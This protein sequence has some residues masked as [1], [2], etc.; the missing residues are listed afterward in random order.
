MSPHFSVYF[1]LGI[2]WIGVLPSA[3]A[4]T[5]A[6][7]QPLSLLAPSKPTT[8]FD[9]RTQVTQAISL[10][11]AINQ[12]LQRNPDLYAARL[13]SQMAEESLRIVQAKLLPTVN[14]LLNVNSA[15]TS[16]DQIGTDYTNSSLRWSSALPSMTLRSNWTLFSS[17]LVQSQLEAATAGL[18]VSTLE[19]ERQIQLLKID[20]TRAYIALQKAQSQLEI[21]KLTLA[22]SKETLQDTEKLAKARVQTQFEVLRA[23]VQVLKAQQGVLDARSLK[24]VAQRDLARYLNFA[25]PTELSARDGIAASTPWLFSLEET[26]FQ[27][28]NNRVEL[29]QAVSREQ[30]AL[31]Q[32][33]A[34]LAQLGPQVQ[35]I[36]SLGYDNTLQFGTSITNYAGDGIPSTLQLADRTLTTTVGFQVS[37]PLTDGGVAWASARSAEAEANLARLDYIRQTNSLRFQ[38]EQSYE[39]MQAASQQIRL[40]QE[41]LQQASLALDYARMRFRVGVATQLEVLGAQADLTQARGALL[42]TTLQYNQSYADLRQ[43]TGSL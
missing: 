18:Q 11:E 22:S 6:G 40:G 19:V 14:F 36:S 3:R 31:A 10:D 9:L 25:V 20:V 13:R 43:A 4:E 15:L 24:V 1:L 23:Q 5:L 16:K 29:T 42:A 39:R 27:A 17:G 35:L 38:V 26:I 21:A 30:Q 41:A 34:A 33:N 37:V 32:G 28:L 12:A 7:G 8:A 2:A